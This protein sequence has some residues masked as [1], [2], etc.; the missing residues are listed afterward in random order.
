MNEYKNRWTILRYLVIGAFLSP[1]DYFIV[2][3]GAT[4][5]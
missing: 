3:Y 5:D 2:N 1:L 4:C